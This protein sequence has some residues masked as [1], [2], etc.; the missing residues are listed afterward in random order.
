[1]A[2]IDSLINGLDPSNPAQVKA[3]QQALQL[4]GYDVGIDGRMGSKT[5]QAIGKYRSDQT[6]VANRTLAS[7]K[8]DSQAEERSW[9]NQ[10]RQML[11]WSFIAPGMYAGHR[12]GKG[13]EERQMATEAAQR[14][15]I[16]PN[17]AQNWSPTRRFL[18]RIAPFGFYGGLA[19]GEGYLLR[20]QIADMIPNETGKDVVR[21]IGSGMMGMGLGIGGH[22]VKAAF[23]PQVMPNS[24]FGAPNL[25]MGP[26][27]A[28]LPPP[29]AG[30]MGG[31]PP[32]GPPPPPEQPPL[33]RPSDRL[34]SAAR[35]GG[36]TGRMTK[37]DAAD[38]LDSNITDANR[39]AVAAELGVKSGPNFASRIATRIKLLRETT[40]PL[41]IGLPLAVG[42]GAYALGSSDAEAAGA[43]P[44]EARTQGAKDAVTAGGGAAVGAYGLSKLPGLARVLSR[45]SGPMMLNDMASEAYRRIYGSGP[46]WVDMPERN[47]NRSV[48]SGQDSGP[49]RSAEALQIPEGIPMPNPDGSSPYPQ[50]PSAFGVPMPMRRPRF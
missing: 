45:M 27:G 2:D 11:P 35:A 39:T 30:P 37:G 43:T 6:D 36:A 34:V 29:G 17:P 41:S 16:L 4:Q 13:M 44:E 26:G 33:R 42:A 48:L 38:F 46:R 40:K 12:L 25:P 5:S 22:G 1:M 9:E 14:A 32:E 3:L 28:A 8:L 31:Q 20:N 23:Q 24:P 49:L 50:L 21:G 15:G 7:K 47:P 10:A 18:G 19:A